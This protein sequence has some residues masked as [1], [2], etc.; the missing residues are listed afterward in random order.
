MTETALQTVARLWGTAVTS[1]ET[2]FTPVPDILIRSQSRLR[3]SPMELAVLLNVC[4]H[5]WTP[6]DWP[7]PRL[8]DISA[9]IGASPRT[10]QRAV[11]AMQ[12][13]GLLVHRPPE[14]KAGHAVR[15]FDLS[16]LVRRLQELAID[17]RSAHQALDK[18]YGSGARE[19]RSTD[20]DTRPSPGMKPT[21]DEVLTDDTPF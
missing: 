11:R 20:R 7:H 4:M 15:R 8:V 6:G 10:V 16:G 13:K 2:G 19:D 9:R 17:Y 1:G 18:Y 21:V 5:W 3:L 12:D 14:P